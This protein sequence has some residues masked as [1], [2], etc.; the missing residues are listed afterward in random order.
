[1]ATLTVATTYA[2]GGASI[3]RAL[4]SDNLKLLPFT[5]TPSSSYATNGDT[6]PAASMPAGYK[7]LISPWAIATG[8]YGYFLDVANSK[9]KVYGANGTATGVELA[10]TTNTQTV[11]GTSPITIFF[12]VR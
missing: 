5:F 9:L 10:N 8:P 1:M 11:L 6:I 3:V 7:D 2:K 12:L 4:F